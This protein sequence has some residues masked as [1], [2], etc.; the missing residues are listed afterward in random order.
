MTAAHVK[1]SVVWATRVVQ[2]VVPVLLPL[3]ATV[4]DAIRESGL[5]QRHAIPMA[6][7]RPAIHGRLVDAGTVLAEGDR[8]EIC[9]PLVA[10]AKE[11][12]R[13]RALERPLPKRP[14]VPK[15]RGDR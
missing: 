11:A 12:R 15:R 4:A 13:Q 5:A 2:D 9:R 7:M 10:D 14:S 8:V 1:V 6:A 3:G